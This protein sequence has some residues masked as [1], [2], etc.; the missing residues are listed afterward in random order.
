VISHACTAAARRMDV[1]Y[2]ARRD[3]LIEPDDTG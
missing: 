3:D 1:R 2:D